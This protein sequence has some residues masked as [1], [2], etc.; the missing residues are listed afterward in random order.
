MELFGTFQLNKYKEIHS[1]FPYLA[2]FSDDLVENIINEYNITTRHKIFVP[3]AGSGTTLLS[4]KQRNIFS[5]G[6][7]INPFVSFVANTKLFSEYN[8]SEVLNEKQNIKE[9]TK[10][11]TDYEITDNIFELIKTA[12]SPKILKKLL[13]LKKAILTIKNI[14]VRNLFL[15]ALIVILKKVSNY[16]NFAPYFELKEIPLNDA[17]VFDIYFIQLSKMLQDIENYNNTTYAHVYEQSASKLQN[18]E[19]K[20]DLILTSP[21]YLNNWDYSWITKIE[22]F[23]LDFVK[24]NQDLKEKL[25]KKLVKSSTYLVN[26]SNNGNLILPKSETRTKIKKLI[27]ELSIQVKQRSGNA[28]KYDI[29]VKEYF[30]DIFEILQQLNNISQ[31]NAKNLWVV[32]DSSLYGVHIATDELIGEISELAGF[33]FKGC[34]VLRERRATRHNEKLRESIV[35][36]EKI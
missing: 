19:T 13:F 24:D 3:F 9:F 1:W 26:N 34:K 2:G 33:K 20:F 29:T 8:F 15:L 14:N 10:Y 17:D 12:F 28:K 25:S 35:I 11:Y 23:F 7:E 16:K 6:T 5:E 27:D 22:L 21:P 31:P 32:G 30:N 18:I 36:M 4:A